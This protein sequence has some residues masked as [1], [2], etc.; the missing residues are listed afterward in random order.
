[1]KKYNLISRTQDIVQSKQQN[2]FLNTENESQ[3]TKSFP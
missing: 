3:M 1:M 2:H